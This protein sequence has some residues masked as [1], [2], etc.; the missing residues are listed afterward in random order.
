MGYIYQGQK[1]SSVKSL[2]RYVGINEK[3]LMARL[4]RGLDIEKACEATDFRCTYYDGKS[5]SQMCREKQKSKEL[6]GNRI[7]YGYSLEEALNRPKCITKQGRPVK[8]KGVA[9]ASVIQAIR[10]LGLTEK[11]ATI[12]SRLHLGWNIDSAFEF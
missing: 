10:A 4:H 3:T 12:R 6:V 1:F 7:K 5:L 2:A 9:Y 8:V 11:E